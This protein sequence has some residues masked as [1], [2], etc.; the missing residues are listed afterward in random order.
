MHKSTV[1]TL[2]RGRM[3]V[4]PKTWALA[5]GFGEAATL[6]NGLNKGASFWTWQRG[7]GVGGE[8]LDA[9][10]KTLGRGG[11]RYRTSAF[12]GET[13]RG[14]RA[15]RANFDPLLQRPLL[16]LESEPTG[17]SKAKAA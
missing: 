8:K 17:P 2:T 4:E 3:L 16:Q 15:W 7:L 6:N 5:G 14:A 11:G 13:G 10:L 12:S 9:H 1:N